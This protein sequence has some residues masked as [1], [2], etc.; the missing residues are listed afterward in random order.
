MTV[1]VRGVLALFHVPILRRLL[2][3][4]SYTSPRSVICKIAVSAVSTMKVISAEVRPNFRASK[5]KK[6]VASVI[7]ASKVSV[8]AHEPP[9]AF[10]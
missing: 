2:I 1:C 3:L 8:V 4:F 7:H 10:E 9:S 5:E 6:V